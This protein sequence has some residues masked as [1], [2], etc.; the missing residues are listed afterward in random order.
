MLHLFAVAALRSKPALV[1]RHT[2]VVVIVG[3]ESL[4]TDRLLAAVAHKTVLVPRGAAVLQ[5]PRSC[6]REGGGE[7][8]KVETEMFVD[9]FPDI[10]KLLCHPGRSFEG[11]DSV[12]TNTERR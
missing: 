1:A 4:G 8:M 3:D 11:S 5:H 6:Q 7:Q 12:H 2:V 10:F 9:I